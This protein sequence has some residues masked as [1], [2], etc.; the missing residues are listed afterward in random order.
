MQA[1]SALFP[2]QPACVGRLQVVRCAATSKGPAVPGAALP[3]PPPA[4]GK[5]QLVST[6]LAAKDASGK[7]FS[8]IAQEVGLTN[9]YTT[10]LFYHQQQLQ[11]NTVSALRKAVPALTDADVQAMMRAPM[12]SYDPTILQEP[13]IYRLHEAITHGGEAIKA[14]INEKFGDGIMSAIG[15]Y[16][17][18]DKLTGNEGEARV[19]ITFNGKF[20]PYVEQKAAENVAQMKSSR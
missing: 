2:K 14:L 1:S 11:A 10:Q 13:A 20:L 18:V 16:A 17:T 4:H 5:A 3:A 19:V 15:F 12:R 8:Q 6:L 9:V 7:T